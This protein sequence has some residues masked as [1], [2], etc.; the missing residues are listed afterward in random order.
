MGFK[1]GQPLVGHSLK[2][3]SIYIPAHLVGR[4]NFGLK[5]LWVG[6]SPPPSTGSLRSD[7]P[8]QSSCPQL[9]GVSDRDTPIDSWELPCSRFHSRDVHHSPIYILSPIPQT[10]TM[11]WRPV[12]QPMPSTQFPCFFHLHSLFYFLF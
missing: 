1:L 8:L 6:W 11:L 7:Q 9:V 3:C 4:I 10:S 2:F 12:P 5:V